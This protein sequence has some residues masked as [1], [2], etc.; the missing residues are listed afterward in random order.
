MLVVDEDPQ[1]L[2]QVGNTLTEA[3]YT[4][5]ATWNPG[6]VERLI[7]VERPHL[8]LL[9]AALPGAGGWDLMQW[10]LSLTDAPVVLL[11]GP[12][13]DQERDIALAF[14][15]GADDYVARPFSSTELV[16]RVGAALRRR[17]TPDREA[18]RES[19][20]FEDLAID[21]ARRRVTL[22]GLPVAL[23]ETEY[24]LLCELAVNA[25]RT[26]GREHLMARVWSERGSVDSKIVRAYVKRVRRK[27]G[28]SADN[29]TYIFNE[30]RVGYRLGPSWEDE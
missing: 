1:V 25:G 5:V 16:A 19:F 12:G 13:G 7:A 20:Q 26:L 4:P 17:E 30:P 9:G 29:P 8:V 3:G 28:E 10:V 11:S 22:G 24:R 15:A 21:Y 27:L 18:Y 6:E 14:E 2:W 23:T